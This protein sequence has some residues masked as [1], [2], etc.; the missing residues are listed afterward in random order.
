MAAALNLA[1]TSEHACTPLPDAQVL[2]EQLHGAGFAPI[3]RHRLM[4]RSTL[5]GFDARAGAP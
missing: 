2:T 1:T 4:P 3:A 5:L